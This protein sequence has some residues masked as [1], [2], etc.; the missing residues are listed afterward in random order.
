MKALLGK[1]LPQN[2]NDTLSL[3]LIIGIPLVWI[4]GNIAPEANGATILAW[5]LVVQFYFR[6]R[7]P[8]E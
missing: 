7:Q 4:Y 3:I 6:Q 2:W 1:L 5:G 8:K